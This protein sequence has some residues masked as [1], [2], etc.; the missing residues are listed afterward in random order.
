MTVE[1]L[2][3]L[4]D[5]LRELDKTIADY[6]GT[7]ETS[8]G[9]EYSLDLRPI[10]PGHL[11]QEAEIVAKD[12]YAPMIGRRIFPGKGW[13]L[14]LSLKRASKARDAKRKEAS[15][16]EAATVFRDWVQA[17][18]TR[19]DSLQSTCD[20]LSRKPIDNRA[21][22][23]SCKKPIRG[24]RGRPSDT[25]TPENRRIVAAWDTGNY[26]TYE[27]LAHELNTTRRKVYLAL[28]AHRNRKRRSKSR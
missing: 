21:K 4:A 9:E 11:V 5:A 14:W 8:D 20:A 13:D 18:I 12:A 6:L 2:R 22:L 26:S 3:H 16:K 10:G 24:M 28:E 23:S 19:V 7:E 1:Q 27:T 17:E 25:D 15:I